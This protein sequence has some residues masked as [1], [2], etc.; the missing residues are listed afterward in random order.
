MADLSR[1][2]LSGANDAKRGVP[3]A[4]TYFSSARKLLGLTH[5]DLTLALG[6]KRIATI[7]WL[8]DAY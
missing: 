4:A 1:A 8:R 5:F 7:Q 2:E 3:K 6:V